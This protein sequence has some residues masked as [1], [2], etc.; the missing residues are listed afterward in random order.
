MIA[1]L[2]AYAFLAGLAGL[3]AAAGLSRLEPGHARYR[4]CMLAALLGGL[5][6]A[7]PVWASVDPLTAVG[8]LLFG[9]FGLV[10][11]WIDRETSW[12]PDPA[13]LGLALAVV[14]I[15]M[16]EDGPDFVRFGLA[17][18]LSFGLFAALQ[19]GWLALQALRLEMP[20]ADLL[21]LALPLLLFGLTPLAVLSW[22]V[23]V[24]AL[25]WLKLFPALRGVVTSEAVRA[26]FAAEGFGTAK[27]PAL[28][29]L[30][31]ALPLFILMVNLAFFCGERLGLT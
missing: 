17:L 25:V 16:P 22:I 4:G 11:A 8:F 26:R 20:P 31:L 30:A 7:G 28:P 23:L 12:A 6:V 18:V 27:S 24:G 5:L 10:L 1:E 21:A 29:L 2:L 9:S 13:V 14:L 3:T 15:A 19:I